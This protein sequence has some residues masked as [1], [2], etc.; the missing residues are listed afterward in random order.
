MALMGAA[1]CGSS[2]TTA[3]ATAPTPVSRC[4]VTVTGDGQVPA[5][6]GNRSFSVSAARECA[7]TASVDGTWL[8]IRAG[9]SGQGDG[10]V[11]VAAAVNPDPQVRR[12]SVVLNEHRVEVTQAA[13]ECSFTLSEASKSFG[14]TG[15]TGA[16]DVRASSALCAWTS[17]ADSAWITL[18]TGVTGK[19]TAPVEFEVAPAS[20]APRSGVFTA[21]GL[22]FTLTQSAA[23]SFAIAPEQ[24]NAGSAGGTLSVTV[25]APAG[26]PWTS[27]SQ[28]PW[29]T[30]RAQGPESG[31]G[32]VLVTVADNTGPAR[33]ATAVIAGRTFTV[34]QA[35]V[36]APPPPP[37]SP[38]PPP[39]PSPPPP[40]PPPPACTYRVD[41]LEMKVSEDSRFRKIEVKAAETCAW[42]ASSN[43][44]WL[45]L[46]RGTAGAGDGE[47][48]FWIDENP[49]EE[50]VGTLTVAGQTVTITQRR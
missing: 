39:P 36:A 45:R 5:Q 41:P 43:A 29:V 8:A 3:T 4:A 46:V 9:G 35:A 11:E 23:C 16:F 18:R 37:P 25:T 32:T 2:A 28:A 7:W 26:C 13:A 30:V 24:F 34:N 42:T 1:G 17:S 14:Q 6:G 49:G 20:G 10:T 19:G 44:L 31:N 40:P 22:R 38:P 12:G 48:W 15:G 50:R 27:V 21:A 33:A 47:V